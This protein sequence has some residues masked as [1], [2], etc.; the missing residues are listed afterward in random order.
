MHY[1]SLWLRSH[2]GAL[3]E[4]K[5]IERSKCYSLVEPVIGCAILIA[6]VNAFAELRNLGLGPYLRNWPGVDCMLVKCQIARTV[7]TSAVDIK[8]LSNL[9]Y[10]VKKFLGVVILVN[11]L[12]F[13]LDVQW[14]LMIMMTWAGGICPRVDF[15]MSESL[16]CFEIFRAVTPYL[17]SGM[18]LCYI[19]SIPVRMETLWVARFWLLGSSNPTLWKNKHPLPTFVSNHSSPVLFQTPFLL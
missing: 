13:R 2:R 5:N 6:A 1:L 8:P 11:G 15:E 9:R 4:G 10:C 18:L 16:R 12:T 19:L 17:L 7:S 3:T 14:G